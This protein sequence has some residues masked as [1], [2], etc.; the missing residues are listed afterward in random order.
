MS[1]YNRYRFKELSSSD[2]P[3][4]VWRGLNLKEEFNE[5]TGCLHQRDFWKV[6]Y[7]HA[8]S[9][10]KV[11][12]GREYPFGPGFV[13]L[14]H[15]EDL[16]TFKLQTPS[17]DITN[18]AF[19]HEVIAEWMDEL[20]G[21]SSF[22][23]I[24]YNAYDRASKSSKDPLYL[25]DANRDIQSLVRKMER[26]CRRQDACARMMLRLNLMELLILLM[27]LSTRQSGQ[28]RR[29]IVTAYVR[30]YLE[31]HFDEELD[32]ES[33]AAEVGISRAYLCTLY[34]KQ[35][36]EPIG[37]TLLGIRLENARRL[38]SQSDRPVTD[39]CYSSG[40]NDL[41]YFYRVFKAETGV[42]PGSFRRDHQVS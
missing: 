6:F 40:F 18:I 34:R 8:G 16:T 41:S 7:V 15:P 27:R 25:L 33:M 39:V 20:K 19:Q 24:F 37:R 4:A 2:F 22:F 32:Y 28:K 1:K 26:E 12:N 42:N 13:S 11:I 30:D 23:S 9:G 14:V 38:L 35:E 21:S 29:S 5:V 3:I 36:G 31:R 10:T 17:I